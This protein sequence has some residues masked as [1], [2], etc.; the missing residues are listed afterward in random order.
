MTGAPET[1]PLFF[2]YVRSSK[3]S[4]RCPCGKTLKALTNKHSHF[5]APFAAYRVVISGVYNSFSTLGLVSGLDSRLSIRRSILWKTP[6][7]HQT[8]FAVP[9]SVMILQSTATTIANFVAEMALVSEKRRKRSP[10]Y[11]RHAVG[12]I[13][14]RSPESAGII[15]AIFPEL[16]GISRGSRP[17]SPLNT[18]IM[19][20]TFGL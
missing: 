14:E 2:C 18:G 3:N 15:P 20:S 8:V 19:Q 4:I 13:P 10:R 16:S 9:R 17:L 1:A 12:I 11:P 7:G 6:Y 5:Q